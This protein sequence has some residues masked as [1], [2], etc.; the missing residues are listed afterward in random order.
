W[1]LP[2]G[3]RCSRPN[4][5]GLALAET[6]RS[7]L[8]EDVDRLYVG[9]VGVVGESP[10]PRRNFVQAT[11]ELLAACRRAELDA[12]PLVP[13][14]PPPLGPLQRVDVH[15]MRRSAVFVHIQPRVRSFCR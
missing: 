12:P 10:P 8:L 9:E 13:I 14:A 6:Q 1:L 2:P 3:G 4:A 11:T 7:L 15:H 5:P